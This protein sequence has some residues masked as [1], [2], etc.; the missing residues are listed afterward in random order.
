MD[1]NLHKTNS[2][3]SD[4]G[5]GPIL[6]MYNDIHPSCDRNLAPTSSLRLSLSLA[7]ASS[8]M[9]ETR[10]TPR[11]KRHKRHHRRHHKKHHKRR[12]GKI[13][14][15]GTVQTV[16]TISADLRQSWNTRLKRTCSAIA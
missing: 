9:S 12:N 7:T 5:R 4:T 3:S 15:Y 2:L 6:S 8:N 11:E 14:A 1:W 16:G 13:R 10:E